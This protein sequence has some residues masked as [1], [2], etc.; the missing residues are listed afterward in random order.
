MDPVTHFVTGAAIG[1]LMLGRKIGRKA[2]LVGAIAGDMPD[3]DVAVTAYLK[4]DL[5]EIIIHRSY[6][7]AII[8]IFIAS[9]LFALV[10]YFLFRKKVGYPSWVV[11]WLAGMYSHILLDSFTTYGTQWFLP[12]TNYLVGFNNLSIIDPLFTLPFLG[13]FIYAICR[14]RDNPKRRRWV[15]RSLIYCCIYLLITFCDKYYVHNKFAE[16]LRTQ[17]IPYATLKTSPTIFNNI[18]WAGIAYN[19]STLTVGEYAILQ[20][21]PVIDFVTFKRN[22]QFEDEFRCRELEVMKWFSQGQYILQRPD[23][24]TLNMYIVKW[25]RSDMDKTSPQGAFIF[26][27]ELKRDSHGYYKMRA[28]RPDFANLDF[29]EAL[30]KLWKRIVDY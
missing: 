2:L 11:F 15:W 4:D 29:K 7:H 27:Y 1:E 18:L 28:V 23:S 20:K 9:F 22:L 5:K 12:V 30:G 14:K 21:H 25:G 17:N 24:N 26:Y 19:D 10:C 6:T 8:P 3:I 16:E 13:I